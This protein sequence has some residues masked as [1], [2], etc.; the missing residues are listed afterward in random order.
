MDF[1]LNS[2]D[3]SLK[4]ARAKEFIILL[5]NG[6]LYFK[7]V[8]TDISVSEESYSHLIKMKNIFQK[9]LPKMPKEYIFKQVFNRKHR[10]L[11]LFHREYGLLGGICYRPFHV[12]NFF[13]IVFLAVD[14]T[15]QIVGNGGLIMDFFK[16]HAK[17]EMIRFRNGGELDGTIKKC[18]IDNNEKKEYKGNIF[19]TEYCRMVLGFN[20]KPDISIVS[21]IN[22]YLDTKYNAEDP[23][24][25]MTYAD[26][27]AIGFF[28]KQG[29]TKNIK[30]NKWVG[31]IKDYEGGTI[32]ECKIYY[33]FNFL[34]KNEIIMNKRD[35]LIKKLEEKFTF[36]IKRD[37]IGNNRYTSIYDIPGITESRFT[38]EMIVPLDFNTFLQN[39]MYYVLSEIKNDKHSWPFLEPVNA[40]EVPDYYTVIKVPM[41]LKTMSNKLINKEY[42]DINTFETDMLLIFKNCNTYNAPSTQFCK[43]AKHLLEKYTSIIEKVKRKIEKRINENY[44]E[45]NDVVVVDKNKIKEE[46]MYNNK[47]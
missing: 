4:S 29:F 44:N 13:E 26:N 12:Q 38:P 45:F 8:S 1:Y 24:Y 33:E 27:Y 47:L 39:A 2:T 37:P 35:E 20:L 7:V 32:M 46:L 23:V 9:Q 18:K 17:L 19:N 3:L 34:K 16:E 36:N 42:N 30:F 21:D 28:K 31:Y 14:N 11:M 5:K 41:D 6:T 43:C 22:Y 25:F 10:N 15:H 40:Q